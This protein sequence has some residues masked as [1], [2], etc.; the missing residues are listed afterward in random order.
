MMIPLLRRPVRYGT[1]ED[2]GEVPE[3]VRNTVEG[4]VSG[5]RATG[6]RRS[7]TRVGQ[8]PLRT[9]LS[10]DFSAESTLRL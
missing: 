6:G 8:Q 10:F 7:V 3:T 2:G 9:E 5:T 4:T 1:T